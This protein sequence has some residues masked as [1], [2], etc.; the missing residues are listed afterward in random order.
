MRAPRVFALALLLFVARGVTAD[1][2]A[3]RPNL[4]FMM[5]DDHASAAISAYGSHLAKMAPTPNIDSLAKRGMLFRNAF[6]TNSICTPSRAVIFTSQYSHKNGVYKFTALDQSQTTLPKLLQQAGYHTAFV[7]KWHLH[8]NPVGFD[9]WSVLPGQ[10]RYHNPQFVEKGDEHANG[11]VRAGKKTSYEGHS[12]DV[13]GTKAVNY[14][15]T[16]G[17]GKPFALFCH[18]KAPH[19]TWEFARRFETLFVGE[20]IPEPPTLYDT[21]EDRKALQTTLQYIG[22]N[23]GHH[24]DFRKQT[25]KL[26]GKAKKAEQYQLYM[27][28]YLRCVRGVD[29]NVGRVLAELDRRKL[30][31]RTIVVY[32]SDQG[33][34]LGEHGLYDK[35]F[36][37][38]D[39]LRVPLL[40]RWPGVVKAGSVNDDIALNL[41]FAPTLLEAIGAKRPKSFQGVSLLPL[42]KG[43]TPETWRQ[44]LYYRYYRSHFKTEPHYGVRTKRYKLIHFPSPGHWELFDLEKDP[45]EMKN[46]YADPEAKATRESLVNEL[47]RLRKQYGDRLEDRGDAPRTGFETK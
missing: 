11:R 23:W 6:V 14:L 42:L 26:R 7:G 33:F 47:A 5:S 40:V 28:K 13:I 46:L 36:M 34:F 8:S 41:D 4:L 12:S 30:A 39:S 18:F 37:Y 9:E 19:D 10:G 29:E 16:R 24:T 22:S 44:S 20:T 17:D 43:Q 2:P 3:D 31:Q 45:L 1:R 25:K 38:E 15:K 21:Y 32:T 35:R 27:K